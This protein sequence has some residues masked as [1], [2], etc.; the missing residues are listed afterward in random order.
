MDNLISIEFTPD[1]IVAAKLHGIGTYEY[2][3]I[4]LK[5]E[6]IPVVEV[7]AEFIKVEFGS[8]CVDCA[9]SPESLLTIHWWKDK[10]KL[11]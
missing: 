4:V 3:A 5:E 2:I 9:D 11:H 1:E 8:C 6:N 10:N 7:N